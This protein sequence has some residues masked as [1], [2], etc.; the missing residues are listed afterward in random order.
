MDIAATLPPRIDFATG[1][2]TGAPIAAHPAALLDAGPDY[3]TQAFRAYGALAQDN[4]VT[5]IVSAQPCLAG[6]SGE[7]LFL[8][9]DYARAD[10]G[11]HRDLFVKFSRHFSDPFRDRRR[12]ETDGEVRLAAL[13]RLPG[14]PVA[15]ARPYFADT[16]AA[17]GTGVL[18][19]QRIA[20]GQ[21][22]IEPLRAKCMDHTLD[23][24]LEH[25]QATARALARLAAGQKAG[26][27]SPLVE[28][29]FPFHPAEAMAELPLHGD[30][31]GFAAKIDAIVRFIGDCPRLFPANVAAPGFLARF[32]E[33]SLRFHAHDAA[34]RAFLFGNADLVTLVH[35]NTNIDNAWFWR[36][37]DGVLEC[38]LLDWGMVRQTN[39]AFG[40]WGG[41]S[42]ADRPMLEAHVDELLALFASE[43]ASHGGPAVSL[44]ELGLHYDLS[45]ML[46][47]LALMADAPLIVQARAPRAAEAAGLLDPLILQDQVAHGFL[48]VFANFLNMWER[49]D[50]G[51]SL[52]R[53]LEQA[54]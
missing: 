9:V 4:A 7:K 39:V 15:A 52:A 38:G 44:G 6:N 10:P 13:S 42:A 23:N 24:A 33:E 46:I 20:F 51:A 14:F 36:K 28:Q 34:V 37:P 35:W 16:E 26:R 54:G 11:L 49:R 22:G 27:L 47:G 40:L 31:A 50:F 19:T 48:H 8:T 17:S 18:I 25:Y 43:Y 41:Q 53:M 45:V 1:D 2:A 29:L 32:R 30:A 21:D 3:L 12:H 5:R